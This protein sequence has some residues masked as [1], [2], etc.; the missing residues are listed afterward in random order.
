[1]TVKE[2]IERLRTMEGN[3]LIQIEVP[4]CCET[5]KVAQSFCVKSVREQLPSFSVCVSALDEDDPRIGD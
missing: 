4:P 1:M 3:A 5:Y 2:L